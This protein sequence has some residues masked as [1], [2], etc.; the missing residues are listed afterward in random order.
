MRNRVLTMRVVIG[1]GIG[2]KPV[3]ELARRLRVASLPL[4]QWKAAIEAGRLS[5]NTVLPDRR[6]GRP[7]DNET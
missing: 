5:E 1:V 4:D 6:V 2:S 7:A 3:E